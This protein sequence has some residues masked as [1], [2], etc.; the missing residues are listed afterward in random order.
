MTDNTYHRMCDCPE[1]QGLWN[2]PKIGDWFKYKSSDTP[3]FLW[4]ERY[5]LKNGYVARAC[6]SMGPTYEF[7]YLPVEE[8][9]WNMLTPLLQGEHTYHLFPLWDDGV[10]WKF[11]RLQHRTN[12]MG[13]EWCF[14]GCNSAKEALIR[15]VMCDLHK[16]RWDGEGWIKED[17]G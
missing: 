2:H 12:D 14:V 11:M 1:I 5:S 10:T 6:K 13:K 16:L 8:D 15:G 17:K 9:L 7:I 3:L 4:D